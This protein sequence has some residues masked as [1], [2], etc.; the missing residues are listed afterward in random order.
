M[1]LDD[2]K[3][4]GADYAGKDISG[5]SN[6]PAMTAAQLKARFDA[7]VKNVVAVKLNGLINE[8]KTALAA[9]ATKVT[10]ATSGNFRLDASGQTPIAASSGG[11]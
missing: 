11:L 5:L 7:L 10:G 6:R 9:L 4:A 2:Y 3:I 8:L 1:A